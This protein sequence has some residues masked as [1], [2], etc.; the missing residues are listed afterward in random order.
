MRL[1]RILGFVTIWMLAAQLLAQRGNFG[2][3]DVPPQGSRVE[4]KTF[5]SKLLNRDVR[6]GLYLPPSYASSL[7]SREKISCFVFPART[8]R[9]R[10]AVEHPWP[11]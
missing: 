2:M 5:S 9:K 3:R 1:R 10:D 6:Y 8:Q 11:D 7:I 4:Y